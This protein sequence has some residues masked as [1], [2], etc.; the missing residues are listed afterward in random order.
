LQNEFVNIRLP[1]KKPRGEVLTPE[2]QQENRELSRRRVVCEHAHA[3]IK[4]YQSVIPILQGEATD[5]IKE[6]SGSS[7]RHGRRLQ[8]RDC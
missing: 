1:H 3:G 8:T 2:Q 7:S 5:V 4:R 6:L